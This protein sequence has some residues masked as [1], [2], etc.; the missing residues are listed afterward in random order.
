MIYL[1]IHGELP[2]KSELE[3]FELQLVNSMVVHSKMI[4]LYGSFKSGAHPMA[5]MVGVV[6]AFSAFSAETNSMSLTATQRQEKCIKMIA[7]VPMISA[8]A[9][10]THMGLPIVYPDVKY[11]FVENF[12]MM[13]FKHPSKEW[14]IDEEIVNAIDKILILHADHEQNASTSTVRIAG[15]TD[16]NPYA[17]ISSGIASLWGPAHGGA[18]EAC[19][20][21]L[22]EIGC[23]ENIPK[24]IAKAKDKQD[25]FRIMGFGHRVYKNYD[26]RAKIMREIVYDVMRIVD[27]KDPLMDVAIELEKIALS[28]DYF[29]TRKLYPNVDFYTGIAY[30]LIGIPIDMYTVLFAMSRTT[31]WMTQWRESMIDEVKK[32]V[33][34]RQLYVGNQDRPFVKIED[35]QE[36]EKSRLP[37]VTKVA[38][39]MNLPV[40]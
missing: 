38:G 40:L 8:L 18:N 32:I 25:P 1:L 29:V 33:R 27:K 6:G 34:P 21:M 36:E 35:R 15:S 19:V 14:K 37:V 30:R 3:I 12:L 2:S 31:G 28:D 16:A 22:E 17:C 20:R 5:I 24:Y 39:M 11:G 9:Y 23:V 4:D 10:R 7:K 13:M 26:P